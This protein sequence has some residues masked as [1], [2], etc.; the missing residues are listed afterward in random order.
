MAL[1]QLTPDGA[2][3]AEFGSGGIAR[4]GGVGH[5]P[6]EARFVFALPDG[7]VLAIGSATLDGE[8]HLAAVRLTAAGALDPAFGD[9]GRVALPTRTSVA[10][11]AAALQSDG[12]IV[13]TGPFFS[14]GVASGFRVAR[15]TADGRLDT[16]F[17]TGGLA[18]IPASETAFPKGIAI[19]PDGRIVVAGTFE[20][21]VGIVRLNPD[22]SLDASFGTGGRIDVD[23][24]GSSVDVNALTLGAAGR[25]LVAGRLRTGSTSAMFVLRRSADGSADV[26]FDGDGVATIAVGT[27][28]SASAVAV[29]VDG[30]VVLAGSTYD[31]VRGT[32]TVA[33]R[34]TPSGALDETFGDGGLAV[35]SLTTETGAEALG[36]DDVGRIVLAG[37]AGVGEEQ[38]FAVV[39][40]AASGRLDH[41]FGDGG[42]ALVDVAAGSNEAYALA[43]DGDGRILVAGVAGPSFYDRDIALARLLSGGTLAST[44]AAFGSLA[45]SVRPNPFRGHATVRLETTQGEHVRVDV[46]D[47]LGRSV[48][49]LHDGPLAA[50]A[51][52]FDLDAALP[53][54]AYLLRVTGASF[55]AHRVV[56]VAR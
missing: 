17:G 36:I 28:A 54:G 32:S 21:S 25:I 47:A 31:G 14:A 39:R 13:L 10:P 44:P 53:A 24:G 37:S 27:Y 49:A 56:T 40:L 18:T 19:Q 33:A 51:H 26:A 1:A 3:D 46:L 2:L 52:T 8:P 45:L 4:I 5:G 42:Q 7:R 48:T 9:E 16:A 43:I 35:L 23:L 12:R 55:H 38:R 41:T 50:G 11:T 34:L 20:N 15:L 22:G 6:S 29:Q 30:A